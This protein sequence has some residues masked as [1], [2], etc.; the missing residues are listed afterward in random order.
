MAITQATGLQLGSYKLKVFITDPSD[1]FIDL[2]VDAVTV[3]K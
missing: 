2:Y 3:E 1:G